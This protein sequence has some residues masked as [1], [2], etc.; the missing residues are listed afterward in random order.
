[1]KPK[2]FA[3]APLAILTV[4]L[5]VSP[6]SA[7]EKVAEKSETAVA[8]PKAISARRV[9]KIEMT[10]RD[11]W[12]PKDPE[13][14]TGLLVVIQLGPGAFATEEFA[15]T[16]KIGEEMVRGRRVDVMEKVVCRGYSVGGGWA[17]TDEEGKGFKLFTGNPT[18]DLDF[19]FEVPKTVS[20]VTL[21]YKGSP[22]GKPLSVK[23]E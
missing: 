10:R 22:T 17:I 1:M 16:Y 19:L 3:I 6:L 13:K 11:T 8:T 4:L 15:L 2:V 12:I 9:E 23:P 14:K 21:L 7:Q 18:T 20:E 5:T